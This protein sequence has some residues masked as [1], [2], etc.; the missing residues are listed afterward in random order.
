MQSKML[1]ALLFLAPALA[2]PVQTASADDLSY[3]GSSSDDDLSS[4]YDSSSY[5]ESASGQD[6]SNWGAVFNAVASEAAAIPSSI[7]TVLETAIPATW[8]EAIMDP[9]SRY[10]IINEIEAGTLPAWYNDLPNSVKAYATSLG[11]D[12]WN[13][14][15]P[16]GDVTN[17]AS[18]RQELFS[19]TATA[20]TA[21]NTGSS[22][23]LASSSGLSAS[24]GSS[25]P[26][27]SQ[28]P[29]TTSSVASSSQSSTPA[30]STSTGGAPAATGGLMMSIAGAAGVLGLAL[31]L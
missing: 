22:V 18:T 17:S 28:T 19:L 1:V 29:A 7:L 15:S 11:E 31:A 30:S 27:A 16:T 10:S 23:W 14:V 12:T 4:Y 13:Y 6:E 25:T 2:S 9:T 8:Y 24:S 21:V 20:S 26:T 5:P 3:G